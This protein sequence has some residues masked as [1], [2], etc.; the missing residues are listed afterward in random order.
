MSKSDGST[1][2]QDLIDQLMNADDASGLSFFKFAEQAS[3]EVLYT[4]TDDYESVQ[5]IL[6]LLRGDTELALKMAS[7]YEVPLRKLAENM[8]KKHIANQRQ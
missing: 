7:R 2:P 4:D 8:L 5:I 1:E 6:A 3:E